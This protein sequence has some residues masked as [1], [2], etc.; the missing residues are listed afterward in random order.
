MDIGSQIF[1]IDNFSYS[2][3]FEYTFNF[4]INSKLIL[5][6]LIIVLFALTDFTQ[7][8]LYINF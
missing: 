2:H 4:V 7:E 1:E 6:L 3:V 5:Q 8:K